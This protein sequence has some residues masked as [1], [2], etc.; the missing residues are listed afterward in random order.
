LADAFPKEYRDRIF[1]ANL[2]E[3]AVL[4]DIMEP[5]GS[6]FVGHHGDETLL[7]NDNAWV[8]FSTEIGP[9][10]AV[11]ILDWHDT[12]ICGNAIH[13]K[14]T[15]RI[16]R[17]APKGLPGTANLD[18]NAKTD[19]ELLSFLTNA[20]DWYSRRARVLLQQR[21]ADGRLDASVPARLWDLFA[22]SKTSAHQLRA[23]W[24]LHVT[25]NLPEDRLLPLFDH[26]EP[27][28][29]GW[30]IQLLG[31][32]SAYSRAALDKLAQLAEKDPSPIVRL[33][34]AAAL[35]RMPLAERWLIAQQLVAHSE[36]DTDHNTTSSF[37][38]RRSILAHH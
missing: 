12:E 19:V 2:H 5:K 20:N 16:Y 38:S 30:A 37:P 27:Y 1:M 4:T 36:D 25:K 23:L 28:V 10:G 17:I 8:G 33:Y 15:G 22:Q 7:A 26:A 35:Q 24:A 9:D 6:G 3:H 32:D 13:D 14:E 34:L 29:R 11:Y 21:A 31:E 18:L